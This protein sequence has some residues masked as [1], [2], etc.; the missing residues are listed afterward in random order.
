MFNILGWQHVLILIAVA[1]A[2]AGPQDLPPLMSTAG[3]WAHKAKSV[4]GGIRRNL[5]DFARTAE[6][7]GLR[8]EMNALK[9]SLP[10]SG[11]GTADIPTGP[12]RA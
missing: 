12:P 2:V 6:L 5:D 11:L 3:K 4:A 10:L 8:A 1:L 9:K 7:D